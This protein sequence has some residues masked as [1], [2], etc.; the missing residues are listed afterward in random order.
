M[1]LK[2]NAVFLKHLTGNSKTTQK[3]YNIVELSDGLRAHV[4][5]ARGADIEA[6][7]E[8]KEEVV[9][10]FEANPFDERN[11]FTVKSINRA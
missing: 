7:L 5:S 6:D 9:V 4:F 10:E 2:I 3:P 11:P 1:N 8:E